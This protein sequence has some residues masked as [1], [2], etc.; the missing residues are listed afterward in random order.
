M[1]GQPIV[2][3]LADGAGGA[4]PVPLRGVG[5]TNT[6]PIPEYTVVAEPITPTEG[7][8]PPWAHLQAVG[9]VVAHLALIAGTTLLAA[10]PVTLG[11][12]LVAIAVVDEVPQGTLDTH[13]HDA[14]IWTGGR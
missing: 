4:C 9:S 1:A 3:V 14:I 2:V 11:G 13:A 5:V 12:A 7:A 10:P 8:G 6:Q